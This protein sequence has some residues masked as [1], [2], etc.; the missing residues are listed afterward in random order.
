MIL[1]NLTNMIIDI[2]NSFK[3]LHFTHVIKMNKKIPRI[4]NKS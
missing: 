3:S 4:S 2:A 1:N